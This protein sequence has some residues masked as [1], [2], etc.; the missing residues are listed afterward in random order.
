MN[1]E[2]QSI[3]NINN[4]DE[5]LWLYYKCGSQLVR[6]KEIKWSRKYIRQYISDTTGKYISDIEQTYRYYYCYLLFRYQCELVLRQ[7]STEVYSPRWYILRRLLHFFIILPRYQI[8]Q[9]II[10]SSYSSCYISFNNYLL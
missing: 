10:S 2:R 9:H 4:K 5:G 7:V 6:K 8:D 3:I 1:K